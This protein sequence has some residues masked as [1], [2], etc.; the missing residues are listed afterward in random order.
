MKRERFEWRTLPQDNLWYLVGLITAD[1]SLSVDRRHIDLTAKDSRF[2]VKLKRI[3]AI[4]Q[5]VTRKS[6]G[7]GSV[8]Y[9]FQI[10]SI[11][12]YKF[13]ISLGLTPNKSKT[14]GPI[15]VPQGYF[16]HFLRGVTD[17]DGGIRT[18]R[19]PSNGRQQWSLRIVS[20]SEEFLIWLSRMVWKNMGAKG[21]IYK[22]DYEGHRSYVLKYGKMATIAVIEACY[23]SKKTDLFLNR[24]Y[25]LAIQCLLAKRG[26]K[27][28]K[29]VRIARVA[30]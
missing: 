9:H 22:N 16:T 15:K 3:L 28:S 12:F 8:A 18:W 25:R 30:E 4:P 20:G 19:H 11:D 21:K 6:N 27:H 5:R 13:L 2:L 26:W 10:G 7:Q 1:G 23:C 14:L 29:L 24:K 17:G